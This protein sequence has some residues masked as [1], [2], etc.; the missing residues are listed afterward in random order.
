M[1][2]PAAAEPE[3][4]TLSTNTPGAAACTLDGTGPGFPSPVLDRPRSPVSVGP[5]SVSCQMWFRKVLRVA[6]SESSHAECRRPSS[7]STADVSAVVPPGPRTADA[8]GVWELGDEGRVG[9]G[10]E[11]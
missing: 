5:R 11:G 1:E 9:G 6:S 2:G 8:V 4:V 3:L 10:W 7:S